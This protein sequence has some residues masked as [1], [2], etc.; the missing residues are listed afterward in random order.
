MKTISLPTL[1]EVKA[2]KVNLEQWEAY[3]AIK[4]KAGVSK[5]PIDNEYHQAMSERLKSVSDE[6]REA[7]HKFNESFRTAIR[8]FA[9]W[10]KTERVHLDA[11]FKFVEILDDALQNPTIKKSDKMSAM[12]ES[13]VNMWRNVA[14]YDFDKIEAV[15]APVIEKENSKRASIA[16][17]KSHQGRLARKHE[18]IN[19][20]MAKEGQWSSIAQ[21]VE[22]IT[23]TI[24]KS[25]VGSRP[26]T[27]SNAR[28]TIRRW[29]S[30][31]IAT[32]KDAAAKLTEKGR[33]RL[34]KGKASNP[35]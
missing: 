11:V 22:Q 26:L 14:Y 9:T 6:I 2:G 33:S 5:P 20:F 34:K 4:K 18:A 16:S 29:L 12:V 35:R 28:Q 21:A 8:P 31:H 25:S 27:R 15:F 17:N 13:V 23:P 3:A 10:F 32:H 7:A 19:L 1:A 30:E 24:L